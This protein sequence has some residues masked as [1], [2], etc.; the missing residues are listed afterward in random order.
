MCE[1]S[2]MKKK[3]YKQAV[4]AAGFQFRGWLEILPTGHVLTNPVPLVVVPK[5]AKPPAGFAFRWSTFFSV[6]GHDHPVG[7]AIRALVRLP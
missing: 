5:D 4:E 1:D 6:E 2:G 3:A 7:T